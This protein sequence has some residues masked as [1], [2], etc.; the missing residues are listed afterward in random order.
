MSIPRLTRKRT[1]ELGD[2][3]RSANPEVLVGGIF[4]DPNTY[5][6]VMSLR[7]DEGVNGTPFIM[8]VSNEGSNL[9][10]QPT[11]LAHHPRH[12]GLGAHGR[13]ESLVETLAV[14]MS[15]TER[16]CGKYRFSWGNPPRYFTPNDGHEYNI[17]LWQSMAC[18]NVHSLIFKG[19][20][21]FAARDSFYYQGHNQKCGNKFCNL[22]ALSRVEDSP[23]QTFLHNLEH[24]NVAHPSAAQLNEENAS[25]YIEYLKRKLEPE[26]QKTSL[27]VMIAANA[28]GAEVYIYSAVLGGLANFTEFRFQTKGIYNFN[29][30]NGKKRPKWVLV[31][32]QSVVIRYFYLYITYIV[33]YY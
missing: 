15:T 32:D 2:E 12:T 18:R 8:Y 23:F 1:R 14:L 17:Y 4:N 22:L 5:E 21:Y 27:D 10:D 7:P 13:A 33:K 11:Y 6:M 30:P 20:H 26:V 31:E 19:N 25:A 28:Y 9:Y 3:A 29:L 24:S 16:V